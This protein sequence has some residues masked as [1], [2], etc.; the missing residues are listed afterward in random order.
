[1]KIMLDAGHGMNT[2]GKR[3]PDNSMREFEYNNVVAQIA[4]NL[5]LEY[6][7]VQIDFAHDPLGERD[8]PL[9]T[10]VQK[11]NRWPADIYISIH[12]N[13]SGN[14][15]SNAVGI[16][17]FHYIA[18]SESSKKLAAI[19]QKKLIE[20]TNRR[21]RGVKQADFQVIRETKMPAILVEGGFMTNREEAELLKTNSY[22]LLCAEAIVE[23]VVELYRL[24][25]KQV[26]VANVSI[27]INNDVADN[28]ASDAWKW[29]NEMFFLDGTNPKTNVTRQEL[30]VV[31]KRVVEYLQK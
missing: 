8:V 23:A 21:D 27:N 22:R 31:L 2:A 20:K 9:F 7:G 6:E 1:M 19:V 30:A 3:T 15:W 16:E 26:T 29:A 14:D 11:A 24:K 13:A 17:T 18:A 28:W 4:K 12:A 5:F 10:R 25:K